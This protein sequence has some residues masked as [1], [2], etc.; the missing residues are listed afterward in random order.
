MTFLIRTFDDSFEKYDDESSTSAS[1]EFPAHRLHIP[2][3]QLSYNS[4]TPQEIGNKKAGE[5]N[6][7]DTR[8]QQQ[9][10]TLNTTQIVCNPTCPCQKQTEH[11]KP[12]YSSAQR[13]RLSMPAAQLDHGPCV[14][15]EATM[16]PAN[17]QIVILTK[18]SKRFSNVA[19]LQ[20]TSHSY[21]F[22]SMPKAQPTGPQFPPFYELQ[23][24]IFSPEDRLFSSKNGIENPANVTSLPMKKRRRI[25]HREQNPQVIDSKYVQFHDCKTK[26]SV[27][28]SRHEDLLSNIV[29]SNPNKYYRLLQIVRDNTGRTH[30]QTPCG[31]GQDRTFS[32]RR[33]IRNHVAITFFKADKCSCGYERTHPPMMCFCGALFRAEKSMYSCPCFEGLGPALAA[34]PNYAEFAA[35]RCSCPI[36]PRHCRC[37]S[38]ASVQLYK[39][40]TKLT[41]SLFN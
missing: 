28:K 12:I 26:N 7:F 19:A 23:T 17:C 22:Q 21:G 39:F 29:A 1:S 13:K 31:C 20:W 36:Q 38:S 4:K 16:V 40:R 37:K 25:E 32:L 5:L 27:T 35:R 3:L 6:R 11:S 30:L 2:P 8:L 10:T 24:A 9:L 14:G 34:F 15:F 41:M 18:E 33:S